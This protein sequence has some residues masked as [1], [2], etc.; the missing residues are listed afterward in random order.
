MPHPVSTCTTVLA[1]LYPA[2]R[3]ESAGGSDHG[4]ETTLVRVVPLT[5]CYDAGH[6]FEVRLVFADHCPH[7]EETDG[8][9]EPVTWFA[10]R[11][12]MTEGLTAESGVGD[13]VLAPI[14]HP[15]GGGWLRLTLRN[16]ELTAHLRLPRADVAA[17][18]ADVWR[19]VPAGTELEHVDIDAELAVLLLAARG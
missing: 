17:F 13:L 8:T 12:L 1:R 3:D 7:Q 19:L 14:A 6:P 16:E 11:E 9:E 2:V 10:A 18:V 15:A 4:L 5:F